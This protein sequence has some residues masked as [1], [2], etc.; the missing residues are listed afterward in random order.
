MLQLNEVDYTIK[1]CLL[2]CGIYSAGRNGQP[3][4]SE[5]NGSFT[6]VQ[7]NCLNTGLSYIVYVNISN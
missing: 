2:N 6:G 4:L 7:L 3:S 1:C 5:F